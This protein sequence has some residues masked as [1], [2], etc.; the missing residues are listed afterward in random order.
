[1]IFFIPEVDTQLEQQGVSLPGGKV[2]E[3]ESKFHLHFLSLCAAQTFEM[4]LGESSWR[5]NN[6]CLKATPPP[7]PFPV[8]PYNVS[9]YR[10]KHKWVCVYLH[11]CTLYALKFCG[12]FALNWESQSQSPPASCHTDRLHLFRFSHIP[13]SFVSIDWHSLV[14]MDF[15]ASVDTIVAS[16]SSSGSISNDCCNLSVGFFFFLLFVLQQTFTA[17]L[18]CN[19]REREREKVRNEKNENC[20]KV[21][22]SILVGEKIFVLFRLVFQFPAH[23]QTR[24]KAKENKT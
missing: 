13:H 19:E 20:I 1:M 22:V 9:A 11:S 2:T 8:H 15:H 6:S 5:L 21:S 17:K 16:S 12:M 24:N 4:H 7:S 3:T 18:T 14:L 23:T 10:T